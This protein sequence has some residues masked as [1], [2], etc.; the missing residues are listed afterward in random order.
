MFE[1]QKTPSR[2]FAFDGKIHTAI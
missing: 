1:L 2:D